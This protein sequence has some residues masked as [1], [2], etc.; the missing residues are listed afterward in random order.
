M[1]RWLAYSGS[2]IDIDRL[3]L[4]PKN[5]LIAQSVNATMGATLANGDCFGPRWYADREAPALFHS[6]E[7]AWSDRNLRELAGAART[8]LLF[9]HIRAATATPVQKTNCHPFQYGRWLW[10]HN[11]FIRDFVRIKRDIAL[12]VAPAL[13]PFIEGS[14]ASEFF[15]HLA[16]SLGLED[17]PPRAVA[18][19]MHRIEEIARA[20]GV[21]NP[22]WMTVAT[23]DGARLWAFRYSTGRNSPS[24]FCSKDIP[25][26]GTM[27]PDHPSFAD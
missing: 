18:P 10:M 1:C 12:E 17:D 5:S 22:I 15:F 27:Y 26:L 8:C 23:S 24:F 7:P 4:A 2:P 14:T 21:E 25:T 19:A 13:Y 6:I 11:G 3:V 16:L 9:A 20:H